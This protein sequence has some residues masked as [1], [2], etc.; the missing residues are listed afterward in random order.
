MVDPRGHY[1]VEHAYVQYYIPANRRPEPPVLLV[2]GG[3]DVGQLLGDD[4]GWAPR[5]APPAVAGRL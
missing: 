5:L 2:H 4:T 3:G 1:A